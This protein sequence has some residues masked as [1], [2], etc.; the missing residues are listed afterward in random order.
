M[1]FLFLRKLF[2]LLSLMPCVGFTGSHSKIQMILFGGKDAGGKIG[3]GAGRV[4]GFV[5]VD[6][7]LT[8]RLNI[9]DEVATGGVGFVLSGGVP[10]T[11]EERSIF[12]FV[13]I[14]PVR[15]P[16]EFKGDITFHGE[17]GFFAGEVGEVCHFGVV[18]GGKSCGDAKGFVD[19]VPGAGGEGG[20]FLALVVPHADAH[21]IAA[22]DDDH[23]YAFEF[24]I[25]GVFGNIG[26]ENGKVGGIVVDCHFLPG[27]RPQRHRPAVV[28]EMTEVGQNPLWKLDF[29][30]WVRPKLILAEFQPV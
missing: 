15:C 2:F 26:L 27:N 28:F 16:I 23:L 20:A 21:P 30:F 6:E 22:L 12:L 24:D 13:D 11:Q 1:Q 3:E 14:Q 17:F 19:F 8:I 7:D 5:E 10:E 25:A 4:V 18:I 9:G 29:A